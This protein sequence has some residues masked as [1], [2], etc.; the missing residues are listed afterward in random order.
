VDH[1]VHDRY[2]KKLVNAAVGKRFVDSGDLVRFEYGGG[3]SAT[4]DGVIRDCCAIEI[5]SR[6]AKQVRGAL[7]DLL[8]HPL[9]RKLLILIPAHMYDPEATAEH[10]RLILERYKRSEE[11]IEVIL[12]RGTGYD[13]R[14]EEDG[15]LIEE[16]LRRLGCLG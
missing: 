13:Q 14:L 11:Q 5:E 7:L 15:K 12:L 9:K 6:V 16:A 2:G 3:V 1:Q 4:I 8:N 10:C